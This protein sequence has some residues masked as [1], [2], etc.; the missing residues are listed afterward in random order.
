MVA[1]RIDLRDFL[2]SELAG[3]DTSVSFTPSDDVIVGTG[4]GVEEYPTVAIA[5]K[6]PVVPGGGQTAAT[7]IDPSGAGAI[8]DT[9]WLCQIDCWGGPAR[10]NPDTHPTVVAGELASAVH[11][12]LFE[13]VPE[14]APAGYE[15][16][17]A[18]PP[19]V[20]DDTEANPT[21]HREIVIARAKS[22]Y[23]PGSGSTGYGD[24]YGSNYGSPTG[25]YGGSYG[26]SYG[27]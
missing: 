8:Q 10:G 17:S 18:E 6:D 22:T 20:A 27:D 16:V 3:D 24:D 4:D 15:W 19:T 26:E 2:R 14:D 9:V 5:S 25:D 13:T 12:A 23:R 7:G 11:A 1:P 21:H